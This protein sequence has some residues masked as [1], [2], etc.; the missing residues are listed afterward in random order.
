MAPIQRCKLCGMNLEAEAWG[1]IDKGF[2]RMRCRRCGEYEMTVE[3]YQ[4][5]EEQSPSLQAAARQEIAAGRQLRISNDN[6]QRLIAEHSSTDIPQNTDKLLN[7]IA[8]RGHHP[9]NTVQL[10]SH[11]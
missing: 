8:R 11:L 1:G 2:Y 9:G 4:D 6:W 5:I 10:D 3:A 7:L